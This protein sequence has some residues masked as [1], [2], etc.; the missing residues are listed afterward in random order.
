MGGGT[1][2]WMKA[3]LGAFGSGVF[4]RALGLR[5]TRWLLTRVLPQ[6]GEGPSDEMR[7]T[8][9]FELLFIGELAGG[10]ELRL[11]VSGDGDPSTESTS[12]LT[13][14]AALCFAQDDIDVGGG[15]WTPASALGEALLKR[16]LESDV[17][18]MELVAAS[19]S[20]VRSVAAPTTPRRPHAVSPLN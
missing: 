1:A 18:R 5:P 19:G 2:G 6:P 13:A 7:R 3:S 16:V 17:L 11:C 4:L 14:E 9:G 10:G 12:K 8:G 20:A 15:F